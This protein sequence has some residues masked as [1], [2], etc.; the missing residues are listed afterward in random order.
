MEELVPRHK[1]WHISHIPRILYDIWKSRVDSVISIKATLFGRE[2]WCLSQELWCGPQKRMTTKFLSALYNSRILSPSFADKT[3]FRENRDAGFT[4]SER[5]SP[6]RSNSSTV[7]IIDRAARY[8]A[9]I[10]ARKREHSCYESS[11]NASMIGYEHSYTCVTISKRSWIRIL[12][13]ADE[14]RRW[15]SKES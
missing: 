14:T 7:L 8:R 3:R 13:L 15:N 1:N 9:W 10:F 6:T 5:I 2:L 12:L 11:G 4:T